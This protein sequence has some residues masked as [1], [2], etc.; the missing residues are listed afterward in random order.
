MNSM[1]LRRFTLIILLSTAYLSVA[2][3]EEPRDYYSP[4]NVRKFADFLYEEGDYLRAAGEYQR[5]LFYQP[6]ESDQIHYKIARCYRLGG[7]SEKAIQLYETFLQVYP[8]SP[9]ASGTYYQI[10][11][12]YFFMEQYEESV[13][14]LDATLPSMADVRHRT[15]SQEL[16]GLSY[17]MQKQ[18]LEADKIFNVLQ[19]SDVAAVRERATVYR[20]YAVQGTQLP[21]RSPFLAGILSTI[22]PGAGRLYTGRLGDALTSLLTVSLTGWQAYDGF[23]KDGLSSAKGWALGTLSGIFYV[24]NIY[25]SVISARVYNR[26]VKDEFLA[27]LSIKLSY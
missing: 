17:L 2:G 16:I 7:Q 13:S 5:Y 12:S 22:I 24:G 1:Q 9:L 26:H 21:S 27:T 15:A 18:W 11:V 19:E 3:A 25:G 14:Y 20:N 10:G 8:D 6:R 23:Q 4:D